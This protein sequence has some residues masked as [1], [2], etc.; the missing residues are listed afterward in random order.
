MSEDTK[1]DIRDAVQRYLDGHATGDP[2]VMRKAFHPDARLQFVRE[3]DYHSWSLE[4]YLAKLPGAPA[5]DEDRRRRRVREIWSAGD[6]AVVELEL[7]YP[8]VR[9]VDYLNLLRTGGEWT[10]VHKLF[11]AFPA[12]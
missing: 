7:D 6:A 10:I 2:E 4:E 1:T 5:E 12:G 11:H 3:G 8:D 9:F